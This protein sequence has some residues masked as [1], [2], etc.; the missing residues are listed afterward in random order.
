MPDSPVRRDAGNKS[1]SLQMLE[2]FNSR[3]ES[4]E[5]HFVG[6]QYWGGWLSEDHEDFKQTFPHCKL[7]VL[8]R[9]IPKRNKII[10]FF[11]YKLPNAYKKN[12]WL[13]V[14]PVLPNNNTIQLQSQFNN[15]LKQIS[16]DYIIISYV[17]WA[18]LIEDNKYL[19]N[20]VLIN[21]THDLIT[22][23]QKSKKR[24]R[25]GESFEREIKLLSLFDETW[26]QSSDEQYLF[27]QFLP[28][29]HRFIPIMYKPQHFSNLIPR[30]KKYD[31]IFVG[32]QNEHNKKS[33]NWFF[34]EVYPLLSKEI[35]ICVIGKICDYIPSFPNVEK[36][37]FVRELMDYY[38]DSK[39]A[40]C[41]MLG[42]TGVKVKVVEAMS[43]GLPIVCNLRGLD[44]L[45]LKDQN[46]CLRGDTKEDFANHIKE[47]L[48]DDVYYKKIQEQSVNMF[49]KYFNQ[50]KCYDRLDKVFK[51]NSLLHC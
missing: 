48:N 26:S 42:G 47:L 7:H 30:T 21:D 18:P 22:A 9:K 34:S 8:S 41:P 13:V 38:N 39:I 14:K 27:S 31:L 17:T 12:K 29:V 40:I 44:G 4:I 19:K 6:E 49:M 45:P 11:R 50:E 2:Y 10:Y 1:H 35:M 36:H 3:H 24:F 32:S 25:L 15:I 16:F 28:G 20:A 51:L 23:Q 46:G 5:L 33:L 37:L 43:F